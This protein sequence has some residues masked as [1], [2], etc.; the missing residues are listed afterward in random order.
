MELPTTSIGSYVECNELLV[1]YETHYCFA[2]M[3]FNSAV[4]NVCIRVQYHLEIMG[5]N[6]HLNDPRNSAVLHGVDV[7]VEKLT[8]KLAVCMSRS[9]DE[10]LLS[11]KHIP[12][13]LILFECC[14]SSG[15]WPTEGGHPAIISVDPIQLDDLGGY[16]PCDRSGKLK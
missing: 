9:C 3:Q 4:T 6:I 14:C 11:Y 2:G 7:T 10:R 8:M 15:C 5:E 13:I 16:F 1:R 12:C